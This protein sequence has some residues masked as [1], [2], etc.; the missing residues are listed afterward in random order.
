M[1]SWCNALCQSSGT[2]VIPTYGEAVIPAKAG[3]QKNDSVVLDLL[4]GSHESR[5]RGNDGFAVARE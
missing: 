5:L 1:M 3:I 2:A 4:R